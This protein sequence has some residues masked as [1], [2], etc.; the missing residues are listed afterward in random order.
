MAPKVTAIPATRPITS[1]ATRQATTTRKVA[2]YARVS[3]ASEEQ[4]TSYE[5]QVDYYTNLIRSRPDWQLAG[6]YTDEGIT[7]TSTKHREGFKRMVTDALAG[8]IDLIVTKSVSRFARNTVD[9]LT[10]VRRLKEA[11]VE[12]FFEKENIWTLDAK[13]ELLIT[14]MSSLAQEESRSI[15]ENVRWGMRKRFADGQV[16]MPY[17]HFLGYDKGKDGRPQINE[18]EAKFVRRIYRLFLSGYTPGRIATTLTTEKVPVP[19]PRGKKWHS[20]TIKSILANEKYRGD[21]LLQKTYIS[22]FLTKKQVKNQGEVAQ[23]YVSG[24]HEAI[25]DPQTWEL[26]QYELARRKG[27]RAPY[28]FTMKLECSMCGAWY[29]SKLWHSNDKYRAVIWQCNNKYKVTHP[30]PMPHPSSREIEEAFQTALATYIADH[31]EIV[32]GIEKT[33]SKIMDTATLE[34]EQSELAVKIEG[35]QA[36]MTK[37]IEANTRNL[38]DQ[39]D[40]QKRFTLLEEQF[41]QA[42]ERFDQISVEISGRQGKL[43]A[44]RHYLKTLQKL[45]EKPV[46]EFS[47]R[48]WHILIDHATIYPDEKIDFI[49]KDGTRIKQKLG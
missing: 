37:E 35:L 13:G 15:S 21:A 46:L 4:A 32:A 38:Q 23:Y 36:M 44:M 30:S 29:G 18:E 26:T 14:I 45:S 31:R 28:P 7:G 9:S 17:P 41:Q 43:A 11:G 40:Y 48:I 24:S 6:I 22:D 16:F 34:T 1:G 25:I 2:A 47:E 5:A 19:N 49:F 10:T 39:A 33:L 42:T 27:Q 8:R 3:T 12:I 20:A